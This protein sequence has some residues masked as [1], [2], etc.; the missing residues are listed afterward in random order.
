VTIDESLIPPDDEAAGT[1]HIAIYRSVSVATL[2]TI[3]KTPLRHP[4]RDHR[5]CLKA[6]SMESESTGRFVEATLPYLVQQ[7]EEDMAKPVTRPVEA[8]A[9]VRLEDGGCLNGNSPLRLSPVT[10]D[11]VLW[12]TEIQVGPPP[13][14]SE[15]SKK[16]CTALEL[17]KLP[18]RQEE[19]GWFVEVEDGL[20]HEG[21]FTPSGRRSCVYR[22]GYVPFH[23]RMSLSVPEAIAFV[24]Q[25]SKTEACFAPYLL[26]SFQSFGTPSI[27]SP[28]SS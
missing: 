22:R 6:I 10:T 24:D 4:R 16:R 25:V 17:L 21:R 1:C 8:I 26:S 2:L 19:K 20:V 13:R 23:L 14:G 18:S 3:L 15:P 27:R 7:C 9:S 12:N 28:R 11:L 5:L